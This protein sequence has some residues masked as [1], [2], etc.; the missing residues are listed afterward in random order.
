VS[1]D[2][3]DVGALGFD[4]VDVET[5]PSDA[6]VPGPSDDDTALVEARAVGLG[7]RPVD[8]S[9]DRVPVDYRTISP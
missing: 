1:D 9:E 4:F 6:L 5:A 2:G 3:V 7:A 8:L